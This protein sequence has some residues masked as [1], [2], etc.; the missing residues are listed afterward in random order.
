MICALNHFH[1]GAISGR[2]VHNFSL[3]DPSKTRWLKYPLSY[4]KINVLK[5]EREFFGRIGGK[6]F[7]KIQGS[8]NYCYIG[9]TGARGPWLVRKSDLKFLNYLDEENFFLG[10]DD[11][12]YH[13]R[14]YE[15]LNKLVGYVPLN[16]YSTRKNGSTRQKRYGINQTV[17]NYLKSRKMGSKDY[18]KFL[19][20]Y[21]PYAGIKKYLI[22]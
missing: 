20:N 19:K 12:D 9:E 18:I 11:H 15:S 5:L 2:H 21:T 8:L 13:R 14:L 6:I 17:F 22:Q 1:L 4:I 10:N 16:I 3:I 7:K